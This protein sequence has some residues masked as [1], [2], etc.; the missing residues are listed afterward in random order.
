M[1]AWSLNFFNIPSVGHLHPCDLMIRSLVLGEPLVM[2]VMLLHIADPMT[3]TPQ[4]LPAEQDHRLQPKILLGFSYLLSQTDY[5]S[6][7][8]D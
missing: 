3:I 5:F 2:L 4:F 7:Q 1:S 8:S 6:R